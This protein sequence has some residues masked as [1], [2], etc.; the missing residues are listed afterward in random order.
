MP[1]ALS[2]TAPTVTYAKDAAAASAATPY[3]HAALTVLQTLEREIRAQA[4]GMHSHEELAANA[5]RS[6]QPTLSTARP[7]QSGGGF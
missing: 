2:T 1:L 3:L 4:T 7:P 5:L 6:E